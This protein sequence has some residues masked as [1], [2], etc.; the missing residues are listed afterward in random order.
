MSACFL[1]FLPSAVSVILEQKATCSTTNLCHLSFN[2]LLL[3]CGFFYVI[4]FHPR[5]FCIEVCLP[6]KG[7]F[8]ARLSSIKAVF[9]PRKCVYLI[10]VRLFLSGKNFQS[11]IHV[12]QKRLYLDGDALMDEDRPTITT[13]MILHLSVK[14]TYQISASYH[15][16]N[17]SKSPTV[18]N[19]AIGW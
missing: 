18:E 4:L 15:A 10:A 1:E 3:F 19:V 13:W 12:L 6:Y 11:Q 8:H 2:A 14:S 17:C 5:L 7:S 9:H 16:Q